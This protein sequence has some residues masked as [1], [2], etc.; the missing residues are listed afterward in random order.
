MQRQESPN[1]WEAKD[2]QMEMIRTEVSALLEQATGD[3]AV[4]LELWNLID[5]L[6]SRALGMQ[7]ILETIARDLP[8]LAEQLEPVKRAAPLPGD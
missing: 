2:A 3:A 4:R 1:P 7:E 8:G 6:A 5:R